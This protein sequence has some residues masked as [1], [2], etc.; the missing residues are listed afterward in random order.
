MKCLLVLFAI[1]FVCA[2]AEVQVLTAANFDSVISGNQF[3]LVEFYAPW[4]GHCQRLEPEYNQ[5]SSDLQAAGSSVILAKVD[6][7]LEDSL[8]Q[9]HGIQGYPTLKF[10]KNGNPVEYDGG[11]TAQEIVSWVTKKSGP[12][13]RLLTTQAEIDAYLANFGTKG[14]AFLTEG[15]EADW[16]STAENP[17]LGL[18][19]FAHVTDAA[20]FGD[21]PAGTIELHKDGESAITYDGELQLST[22]FLAEGFPLVDELAQESWTRALGGGS[23]LLAVFIASKDDAHY[24]DIVEVAKAFKGQFVSTWSNQ[25][26]IAGRWG[27]SGE[28]VPTAIYVKNDGGRPSFVIWDEE[29]EQTMDASSLKAFV[30][31]VRAGTYHSFV[32]SEPVPESNDGPVTV[33]VGKTFNS[34]VESDKNVLIEF[35]A[36]WCGHCQK[37]AP[38]Y[39]AL[40]AA[41]KD[42]ENVVIAKIDATANGIPP[43]VSVQGFPTI[44]LFTTNN[45]QIPYEG[46]RE[47]EAFKTFI[48]Q[49]RTFKTAEEARDEL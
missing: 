31:G 28:V 6:A 43:N 44:I 20:L 5:A 48:E 12:P 22:W 10:F 29:N 30:E 36:P 11:R 41:Y 34:I 35:Y 3:V 40:G 42:D 39:D 2:R 18:F 38:T 13:S 8:A 14:L 23:D 17:Q 25:I 21:R 26:E 15:T 46:E 27:A 49:H 37:L 7:T 19:S 1:A 47:L 32:K 16:V 9:R 24:A 33:V 4:C 45:E